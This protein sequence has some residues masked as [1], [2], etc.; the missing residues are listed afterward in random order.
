MTQSLPVRITVL[1]SASEYR[2]Y[3]RAAQILARMMGSRDPA[4]GTLIQAQLVGRD[5]PGVA[6]HY[7]DSIEWPL[8]KGRVVTLRGS[9]R[10]TQRTRKSQVTPKRP[11]D[12]HLVPP[13]DPTRN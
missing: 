8:Q 4:V 5:A 10:K 6:D 9:R 2:A 1:L 11:R 12:S 7:L 13:H 3:V